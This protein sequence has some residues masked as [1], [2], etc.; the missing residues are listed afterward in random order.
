MLRLRLQS[1]KVHNIDNPN[2]QVGQVLPD[3]VD[4]GQHFQRGDV[5]GARHHD[6]RFAS[7]VAACPGPEAQSHRAVVYGGIHVEVLERGLLTSDYN[8]Y[9]IPAAQTMVGHGEQGV[10]VGREIDPDDLRLLVDDVI[11]ETGILVAESIVVLPPDVR[12]EQVIQ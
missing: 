7:L 1:H 5:P 12:G 9:I 2:L 4:C 8:V 11:D 10:G 6:V 3:E